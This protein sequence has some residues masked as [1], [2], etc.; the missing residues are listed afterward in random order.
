MQG[1]GE[2]PLGFAYELDDAP[3]FERF[4]FL[5]SSRPFALD[6]AQREARRLAERGDAR[7]DK[8]RLPKGLSTSSF[9]LLKGDR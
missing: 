7:T 5:T 3:G 9:L 8:P 1:D 4:F 6:V 2:V